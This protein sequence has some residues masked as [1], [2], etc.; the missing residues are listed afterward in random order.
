[1]EG[2]MSDH[3]TYGAAIL[4]ASLLGVAVTTVTVH[5]QTATEPASADDCLAKPNGPTP[6]GSHWYYRLDRANH[7]HCWYLRSTDSNAG[8]SET[9]PSRAAAS[10][11]AWQRIMTPADSPNGETPSNPPADTAARNISPNA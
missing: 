8:Q 10:P 3:A 4:L 1:M 2:H 5:A 7:R 11:T 6:R 9:R